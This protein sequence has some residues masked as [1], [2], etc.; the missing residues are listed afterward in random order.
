MSET[1]MTRRHALF[2]VAGAATAAAAVTA[3]PAH[4]EFQPAM[5]AALGALYDAH[6]KLMMAT[7]DKGGH[8]VVALD[9]INKAILQVNLGIQWDNTH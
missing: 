8:R 1:M 7:A 5:Q 6:S 2:A 3:A 9:Y 4:A